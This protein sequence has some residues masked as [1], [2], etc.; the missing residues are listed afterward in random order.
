[1]E[2]RWN[3][4]NEQTMNDPAQSL[5]PV[6]A[7]YE[8]LH[9]NKDGTVSQTLPNCMMVL[10]EDPLFRDAIRFNVLSG[11]MAVTREMPWSRD[12][13]SFT[14]DDLHNIFLYGPDAIV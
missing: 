9:R 13:D 6:D 8:R 11:R 7:I 1:M 2:N 14:D 3:N 12:G 4:I 10:E 5:A